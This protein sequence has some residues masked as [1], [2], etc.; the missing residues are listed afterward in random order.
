MVAALL[1]ASVYH[2]F[3]QLFQDFI[4]IQVT[5]M[6]GIA[7]KGSYPVFIYVDSILDAIK[8]IVGGGKRT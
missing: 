1:S 5:M 6:V 8:G 4:Q 2:Y 7:H 3:I